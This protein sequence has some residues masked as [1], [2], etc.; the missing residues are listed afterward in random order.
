MS[1]K[2][3][4][5]ISAVSRYLPRSPAIPSKGKSH[6]QWSNPADP[7]STKWPRLMSPIIRQCGYHVPPA[8]DTEKDTTLLG[9][10]CPKGITSDYSGEDI[11][12][13]KLRDIVQWNR[14][15]FIHIV[16][17]TGGTKTKELSQGGAEATQC[18]G[19]PGLDPN[20]CG[21]GSACELCRPLPISGLMAKPWC[22]QLITPGGAR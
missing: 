2:R 13:C 8:E 7:T 14:S 22:C 9:G 4:Y 18:P 11:R 5:R 16:K 15:V 10:S 21:T 3:F 1:L 17:V 20:G 6:F 19:E 12:P